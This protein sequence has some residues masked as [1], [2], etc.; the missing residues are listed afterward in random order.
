MHEMSLMSGILSRAA[1]ALQPY[2]VEQVK[3]ITVQVGVLA[4]VLPAAFDFAF[5]ALCED[6][7]FAKAELICETKPIEAEC[8]SCGR[9]FS[10]DSLPLI[11]PKCEGREVK[12]IAGDEVL[13]LSI[14]F[15]EKGESDEA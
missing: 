7:I 15:D 4:N 11:C 10:S 12:I 14:N 8:L 6:S 1:A 9:L 13:L 3:S 2:E 5:E